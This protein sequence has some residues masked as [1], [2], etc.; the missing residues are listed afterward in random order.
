MTS[1]VSDAQDKHIL[2]AE[3]LTGSAGL[4]DWWRRQQAYATSLG[5]MSMVNSCTKSKTFRLL[6]FTCF[7]MC[8]LLEVLN[9]R[10]L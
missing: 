1:G 9:S 8:P 2:E 4:G 3:L 10:G 7:N 5:A 6:C